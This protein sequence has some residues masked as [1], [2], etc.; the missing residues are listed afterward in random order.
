MQKHVNLLDLVKKILTSIYHLL[1][2]IDVDTAEN[3]P[4]KLLREVTNLE[5]KKPRASKSATDRRLW[6]L[7]QSYAES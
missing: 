6:S 3:E 1:A 5:A 2:K 4:I 7:R